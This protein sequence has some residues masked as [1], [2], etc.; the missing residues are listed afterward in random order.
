MKYKKLLLKDNSSAL[1]IAI[2]E[3]LI[4]NPK[5]LENFYI[6]GCASNSKIKI[7]SDWNCLDY[8]I[9]KDKADISNLKSSDIL[10]YASFSVDRPTTN[11][12]QISL[13]SFC[14]NIDLVIKIAGEMCDLLYDVYNSNIIIFSAKE[15]A[16]TYK[17]FNKVL[18]S[19]ELSK[20]YF[21]NWVGRYVGY[22]TDS[23]IGQNG[24]LHNLHYF[25]IIRKD[26]I[27]NSPANMKIK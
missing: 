18:N 9:I 25:E 20:K 11:I 23:C 27:N 19:N 6:T 22:K 3:K 26:Y 14:N 24:K 13:I 8:L 5:F 2:Q 4:K 12:S 16:T 15:G 21:N 1:E 17:L 10:I 7:S